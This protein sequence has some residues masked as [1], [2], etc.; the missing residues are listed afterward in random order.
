MGKCVDPARSPKAVILAGGYG[1]RLRPLTDTVPKPLLRVADR[2]IIEWQ[3]RW[4]ASYGLR[5]FIVCAGYLKE[6]LVEELGSGNHLGVRIGYV[7]ESEPLGTAGALKN[8]EHLLSGE[9]SFLVLNGDV[10][11]DLNP[12][13]VLGATDGALAAMA[14][15]PLPSPYGIVEFD[16]GTGLVRGF[17]EK[18][19]LGD[20]WINAGVY[21]FRSEM[22]EEVPEKGDLE[23][24]V[25]P[26][27]AA[28]GQL[29]AVPFGDCF[30][31]SIDTHKDMEEVDVLLRQKG[32]LLE[33]GTYRTA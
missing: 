5:S 14:V 21:A 16:R 29:V 4:L 3:I 31:K 33:K 13:R 1:K 20:H 18:P 24:E 27:L 8:A 23:R 25:F 12:L 2:P 15:V 30:W 17:R 6:R 26:R 22:L 19:V 11:T 32:E 28:R 7:F 9:R 10:L